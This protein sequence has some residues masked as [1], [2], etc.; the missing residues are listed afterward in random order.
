[1]CQAAGKLR[2]SGFVRRDLRCSTRASPSRVAVQ[3]YGATHFIIGRDMAGSKS[4]LTG[5]D[6][7]GPYEAQDNAN[8]RVA[9]FLATPVSRLNQNLHFS[10][11]VQTVRVQPSW[12]Y[13]VFDLRSGNIHRL[14]SSVFLAHLQIL[15]FSSATVGYCSMK[16]ILIET[17]PHM[18]FA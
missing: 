2:H 14:T 6:F 4:S 17:R 1:M 8:R 10:L 18:F 5:D 13:T 16:C 11:S 12:V 3:N 7:Y 9:P 15:V